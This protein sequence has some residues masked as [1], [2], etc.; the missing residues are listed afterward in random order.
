MEENGDDH[1]REEAEP[2]KERKK[3]GMTKGQEIDR[4]KIKKERKIK[5]S[6]NALIPL[7]RPIALL[8]IIPT[9]P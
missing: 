3:G 9:S 4:E 5:M 7:N 2:K 6:N 1:G 8:L